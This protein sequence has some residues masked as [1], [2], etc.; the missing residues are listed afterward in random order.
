[1]ERCA[2][3]NLGAFFDFPKTSYN[4]LVFSSKCDILYISIGKEK[5]Y[6]FW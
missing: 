4:V 5:A 1:M 3:R 2:Q 6:A